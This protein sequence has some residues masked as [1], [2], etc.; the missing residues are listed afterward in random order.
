MTEICTAG[1]T[2]KKNKVAELGRAYWRTK[3]QDQDSGPRSRVK[4]NHPRKTLLRK[5][6]F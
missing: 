6:E 4:K 1:S 2:W 3:I 5:K